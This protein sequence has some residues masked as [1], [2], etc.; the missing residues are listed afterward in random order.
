MLYVRRRGSKN[1][2]KKLN[3]TVGF[4]LEQCE[5]TIILRGLRVVL[6]DKWSRKIVMVGVSGSVVVIV[7]NIIMINI[8]L[9]FIR[10]IDQYE[11]HED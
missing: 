5:K 8:V 7:S 2:A 10:A 11:N 6:V 9:T 1:V 4:I 3:K